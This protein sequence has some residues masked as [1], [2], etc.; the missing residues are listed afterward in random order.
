RVELGPG[1]HGIRGLGFS[2]VRSCP[3]LRRKYSI[4]AD[5][6]PESYLELL[7]QRDYFDRIFHCQGK[8]ILSGRR[9]GAP[10]GPN[11][12]ERGYCCWN[13]RRPERLEFDRK[14]HQGDS[15]RRALTRGFRE[16]A[17]AALLAY[18]STRIQV[19]QGPQG[20]GAGHRD[21]RR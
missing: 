19:G 14:R 17:P 2:V 11:V 12:R 1:D 7:E 3:V 15:T 20:Q 18:C 9:A 6:T 13:N 16:P 4:V 10:A 8:E 5:D 21:V